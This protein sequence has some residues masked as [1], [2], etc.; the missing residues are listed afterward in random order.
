M[1]Q[2]IDFFKQLT[3]TSSWPPRWQ[4]GHWTDL[5]GWLYIIG[6]LMVWSAY[7]AIPMVIVKYVLKRKNIQFSRLYFLFALFILACGLTHLLSAV[8]FWYPAYRLSALML[9][10]TGIISWAT[11]YFLIKLLPALFSLRSKETLEIEIEQRK[12]AEE[13]LQRLNASLGGMLEEQSSEIREYK[14]A[15]DQ[16]S[17]VA[18]TDHAGRITYVNDNFC[19]ISKFSKEELIGRAFTEKINKDMSKDVVGKLLDQVTKGNTWNGELCHSAKDDTFF[20]TASTVVP[21]NKKGDT[22][23]YLFILFDITVRRNAERTVEE[24]NKQIEDMLERI[25]DG[26]I[27]LDRNFNYTYVN[28]KIGEM[29]GRN[30][31]SLIGKNVWEEFPDAKDSATYKSFRK[32]SEDQKYLC[33]VDYY[34]PL[35]LWQE[36]H[37]YPTREG[38]SIFIRDITKQKRAEMK[39]RD[40]EKKFRNLIEHSGDL[41][42]LLDGDFK[43]KYR[44]PSAER[45]TGKSMHDTKSGNPLEDLHPDDRQML[46]GVF[47][48]VLQ[49]PRMSLQVCF[50][51]S[52]KSQYYIWLE[53]SVTNMMH[54]DSIQA[55]VLN[56][57][58]VTKRKKVEEQLVKSEKIYKTIA[59]NIPGSI[60]TIMDQNF[61][62]LLIEGDIVE[63]IGFSR[64][65]IVERTMED[66]LSEES[67]KTWIDDFRSAFNG[68]KIVKDTVNNGIDLHVSLV[69]LKDE[70]QQVYAVMTVGMDVTELKKAQKQIQEMNHDL[71]MKIQQRTEELQ[72]ANSELEAFS[73][74]V[75]HDLRAPLRSINGYAKMLEEDYSAVLDADGLRVLGTVQ[76][77]AKRMGMLIDD[78]LSFSQLGRM[79]VKRVFVDMKKIVDSLI[80]ELTEH[81]YQNTNVLVEDLHPANADIALI[82]QVLINFISNALKYSSRKEHPVVIIKS[83][84]DREEIVY[85]VR[86]NGTGFNMEYSHKLFNVFQRLHS[87]AEFEGTG[88][89][90]AIVK[91]IVEKHGGKV[92]AEGNLDEGATFYFSLPVVPEQ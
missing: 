38:L 31:E 70:N 28:K 27:S 44:S 51:F 76:K 39:I 14:Y 67:Y 9:L 73:Y 58:D 77:N 26:F 86:D 43:V 45:L 17:I 60:I 87:A 49:N 34:E 55:I 35:D 68:E 91:R 62:Y 83:V 56:F 12:I 82:K 3:D 84:L 19:K 2:L 69:P 13:K 41:I 63:T 47:H 54:E 24:K 88:V 36:N 15:L 85:S 80:P 46:L 66:V 25:T 6:D 8:A 71:E 1:N 65:S 57:R 90:L 59:S 22:F 74:S 48:Q 5:H 30:P 92:W 53:G 16:A 79:E 89:G 23:S 33:S 50:R 11:V 37:I 72:V 61:R 18:I 52:Y 42:T 78:L 7:F 4:C 81:A 20:W 64:E 75:S 29:T 10:V 40:S 32:A 21:F